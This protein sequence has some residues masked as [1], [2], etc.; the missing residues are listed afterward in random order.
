[1]SRTSSQPLVTRSLRFP[2][3]L[4][5]QLAKLAAADDRSVN[6][7]IVRVLS[8]Y[9]QKEIAPDQAPLAPYPTEPGLQAAAQQARGGS[10]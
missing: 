6:A 4:N 2:P 10:N 7:Y 3:E 8:K 9:V 1:M 5:D